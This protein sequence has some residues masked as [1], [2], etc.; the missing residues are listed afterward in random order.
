M[1]VDSVDCWSDHQRPRGRGALMA[2]HRMRGASTGNGRT[3][4]SRA[5]T[6]ARLDPT[7]RV[8][9]RKTYKLFIGGQFPRSESGR[10]YVVN[11]ADGTALA[12]AVRSSKKDLRDAV[13]AARNA[14]PGWAERTAMN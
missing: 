10:S 2:A 1:R 4:R 13:R 3:S 9:V 8:E 11:A 12:N 14:F 6:R 7:A 5:L